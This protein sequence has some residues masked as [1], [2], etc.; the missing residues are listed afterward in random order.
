MLVS[1]GPDEPKRRRTT[2]GIRGAAPDK[3]QQTGENVRRVAGQ[4]LTALR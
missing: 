3:L 4:R 2:T 1:K